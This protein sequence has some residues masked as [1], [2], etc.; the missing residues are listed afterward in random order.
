[1]RLSPIALYNSF[2]TNRTRH[3]RSLLS[4][5]RLA[6]MTGSRAEKYGAA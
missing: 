3:C 6:A 2:L 1:M 5:V 4:L